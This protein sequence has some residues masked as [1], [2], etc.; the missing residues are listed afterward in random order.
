LHAQQID[1]PV[2]F[3][4]KSGHDDQRDRVQPQREQQRSLEHGIHAIVMVG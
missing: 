4:L 1:H 3:V 2:G